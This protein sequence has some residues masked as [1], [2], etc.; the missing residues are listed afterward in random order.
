MLFISAADHT[1][2]G[3]R[4]VQG[5]AQTATECFIPKQTVISAEMD[6]VLV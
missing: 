4:Q 1:V 2:V 3:V 6:G 5:L